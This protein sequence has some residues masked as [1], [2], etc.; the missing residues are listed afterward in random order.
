M[1][2]DTI[3]L[4]KR[5]K[6]LAEKSYQQNRY[7]YTP[8]LD[9]YEQSIYQEERS[10]FAYVGSQLYGGHPFADR[11]LVCFGNEETL[12]YVEQPPIAC[13]EIKPI[14]KKFSDSLSHR[15]FL[16]ALMNLGIER[17]MLGDILVFDNVGYVFCLEH[18]ADV[19][20]DQL[21]KVKH[22]QVSCEKTLKQLH[23]EPK[24][25]EVTG[26]VTS[27]RLDSIIGLAF[28]LSRS[29]SIPYIQGKK[30]FVNGRLVQSNSFLLK[31]SDIISVRGLGKFI[32]AGVDGM[33]K[34]GR[35]RILLHKLI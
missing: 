13:I 10:S 31:D 16:G 27:C 4:K 32:F 12:G 2:K 26:F 35:N 14:S 33:T 19:I 5:L 30:V 28:Q 20:V 8:F 24:Y 9:L 15:D 3:I 18:I 21:F 1:D 23:M 6:E 11:Q 22:T 17:A 25:Q 34:K 7:T 29:Q